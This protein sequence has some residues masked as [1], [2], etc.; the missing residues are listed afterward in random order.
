M[1]MIMLYW[2]EPNV[3]NN[4]R[5]LSRILKE[6]QDAQVLAVA[7][8]DIGQYVK[9]YPQGKKYVQDL[10]AKTAVM[11]LMTHEHKDV[12]YQALIAVQKFMTNAWEF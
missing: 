1:K 8:S 7:A 5:Q 3:T 2:G 10:G 12:R 11:Q 9:F 6:S 4:N